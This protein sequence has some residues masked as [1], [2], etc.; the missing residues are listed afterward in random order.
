M[1]W[2]QETPDS[3]VFLTDY[4][5]CMTLSVG[6]RNSISLTLILVS[7][8]EE[9]TCLCVCVCVA[10]LAFIEIIIKVNVVCKDYE[11]LVRLHRTLNQSKLQMNTKLRS[12]GLTL[13]HYK[14]SR[15]SF[16]PFLL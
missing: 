5:S 2:Q 11:I 1:R 14:A 13:M 12:I 15:E 10:G 9:H 7:M 4:E 16:K 3:P 6:E 8:L